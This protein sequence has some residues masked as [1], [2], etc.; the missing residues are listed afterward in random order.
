[1]RGEYE[2]N[3]RR[4]RSQA[5]TSGWDKKIERAQKE[6][7][8]AIEYN[9]AVITQKSRAIKRTI[10]AET[11]STNLFRH[12]NDKMAKV[13][14]RL[15]EGWNALLAVAQGG[16]PDT[17]ISLPSSGF[18]E[19]DLPQGGGFIQRD[20]TVKP[21]GQTSKDKE[22]SSLT[23]FADMLKKV[24]RGIKSAGSYILRGMEATNKFLYALGVMQPIMEIISPIFEIIGGAVLQAL[25]PAL[26]VL[27]DAISD[28]DF[29]SFLMMIG[30]IIGVLLSP[31]L[32][33][34][35]PIFMHLLEAIEPLLPVIGILAWLLGNVLAYGIT[36]I[37]NVIIGI[38]NFIIL[39]I[40]A[41]GWLF[42]AAPIGMV[43]YMPLP[44]PTAMPSYD[45]GGIAISNQIARIDKGEKMIPLKRQEKE[46]KRNNKMIYL[47]EDIS[48]TN[49]RI[50]TYR[51][52]RER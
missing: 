36:I 18:T 35:V 1:M 25:M 38:V 20:G 52:W 9:T 11:V 23:I 40:N 49:H 46:D 42:G 24:G 8:K 34:I 27:I 29:I 15:E 43:S 37:A 4:R 28:P 13:S 32:E 3:Q 41:I 26:Q 31:V 47:L 22:N 7:L 48:A 19:S 14:S 17:P 45:Q 10:I 2:F 21:F 5:A 39:I 12:V 16:R 44:A 51:D 33:A 6:N 50:V 30:E